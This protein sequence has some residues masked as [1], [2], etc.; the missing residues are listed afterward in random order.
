MQ[1]FEMFKKDKKTSLID[2]NG[3]S[4]DCT[5]KPP[6]DSVGFSIKGFTTFT[7]IT[8]EQS[9]YGSFGD[10]FELTINIDSLREK[11]NLIP[12]KTWGVPVYFPAIQ[13][14]GTFKIESAPIDRTL[15]M[16]LLK[17]SASSSDGTGKTVDRNKTG[18]I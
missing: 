1:L 3:F 7:G 9:G 12:T 18:G 16:I 6:G 14:T 8:V 2:G 11:T 15:G 5:L 4:V 17:C 13:K 10:T